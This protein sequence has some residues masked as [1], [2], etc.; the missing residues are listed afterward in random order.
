MILYI[1]VEFPNKKPIEVLNML[2]YKC[3]NVIIPKQDVYRYLF[4][5]KDELESAAENLEASKIEFKK[6]RE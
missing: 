4:N 5:S 3:S 1:D 6:S 2:Y